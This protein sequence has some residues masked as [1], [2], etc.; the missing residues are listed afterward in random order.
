MY[1]VETGELKEIICQEFNSRHYLFVFD[2]RIIYGEGRETPDY[3]EP[4][5]EKL[6]A[7]DC[8]WHTLDRP[9][10]NL[11]YCGVTLIPPSSFNEFIGILDGTI[12]TE[13]L[14]SLCKRI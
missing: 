6:A 14:R 11:A 4:L 3:I 2:D 5:L 13:E 10:K 9:K 12:G 7:L 8:F 1:S